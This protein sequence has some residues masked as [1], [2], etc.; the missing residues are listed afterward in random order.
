[1]T[2]TSAD[3]TTAREYLRVS[4]DGSGEER[5]PDEQHA[6]HAEAAEERGWALH[7][8]PY[9]DLGSASHL[10]RKARDDYQRMLGD[11][12]A[13]RFGAKVLLLWEGSRGSRQVREWLDLLDLLQDK[14]I[15]V[16]VHIRRRLFDPANEYDWADLISDAVKHQL[17]SVDTS[18][19]IRR[20]NRAQAAKGRPHGRCPFG[21]RRNYWY[22]TENGRQIRHWEQVPHP[23]E[24]PLLRELFARFRRGHSLRSVAADWADRGVHNDSGRPFTAAHLRALL[25]NPAYAGRRVHDP[26]RRGRK[27]GPGT[28]AVT[29]GDWPALIPGAMFDAAQRVLADPTRKTSRPGRGVH[30]LSMI[31][32]CD[33]CGGPMAARWRREPAKGGRQAR[34][35]RVYT[36]HKGNCTSVGY[37]ALDAYAELVLLGRLARED[38]YVAL[39]TA[40]RADAGALEA[41]EAEAERIRTDMAEL[42][43]QVRRR[44]TSAASAGRILLGWE[45]DL[46]AAERRAAELRT[47][48]R[49]AGLVEPGPDVAHRWADAPMSARRETVRLMFSRQALGEL[50]VRRAPRT[51]SIRTPVSDRAYFR[52]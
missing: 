14:G 40:E 10:A 26:G 27:P 8:D 49:L 33:E 2:A 51:G 23:E 11:L 32:L 15:G 24:A 20:T 35:E 48:S 6:E 19:R 28:R 12:R 43:G 13:D 22:T 36:C 50:R 37:D 31:A 21:Y 52:R 7:P 9:R 18:K 39:A 25:E 34:E 4:H 46:K 5:S 44:E 45:Q 30:L 47:P 16:Y 3:V 42:E 38:A 29:S 1:M 17:A 41:A